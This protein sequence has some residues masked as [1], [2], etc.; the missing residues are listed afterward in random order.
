MKVKSLF[1]II[2]FVAVSLCTRAQGVLPQFVSFSPES[3]GVSLV[4]AT[5]GY[6]QEEYEGVKMAIQN[7]REDM[8]RVL[9]KAPAE[10]AEAP[11]ILI[12]FAIIQH[13][14]PITH[15]RHCRQRQAWYHLWHLRAESSVGCVALVLVG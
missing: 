14:S 1:G 9:G 15:H 13:P 7:L 5:I 8:K 12:H 6:S 4:N 3:D 10:S 11:T 2:L